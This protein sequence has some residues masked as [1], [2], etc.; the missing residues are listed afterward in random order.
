MSPT[1]LET[2]Q[3]LLRSAPRNPH[4]AKTHK[5]TSAVQYACTVVLLS[6]YFSFSDT[7]PAHIHP[8]VETYARA[9]AQTSTYM[10]SCLRGLEYCGPL[11][12]I[13]SSSFVT[14]GNLCVTFQKQDEIQSELF[15]MNPYFKS[16]FFSLFISASK[17][18][19][20]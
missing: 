1:L 10:L 7:L 4:R 6:L 14:Q 13:M 19:T 9:N 15:V 20:C 8:N 17:A 12:F 5:Y 3:N 16:C 18:L 2:Q 11:L